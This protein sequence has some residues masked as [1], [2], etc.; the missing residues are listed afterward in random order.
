MQK[1]K[2]DEEDRKEKEN[3]KKQP[4][5]D[6]GSLTGLIDVKI[7]NKIENVSYPDPDSDKALPTAN[8]NV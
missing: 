7:P 8:T 4:L 1:K 3:R 5:K 2:A 6:G